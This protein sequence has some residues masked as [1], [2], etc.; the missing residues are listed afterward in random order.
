MCVRL[1]LKWQK[2]KYDRK[3]VYVSVYQKKRATNYHFHSKTQRQ[4]LFL[5]H[6]K[7]SCL[8]LLRIEI[9]KCTL[10]RARHLLRPIYISSLR[11]SPIVLS[12]MR[13]RSRIEQ[14]NLTKCT[15]IRGDRV[16]HCKQFVH[17]QNLNRHW[18]NRRSRF[19]KCTRL[20][21]SLSSRSTHI[22]RKRKVWFQEFSKPNFPSRS[23]HHLSIG[24]GIHWRHLHL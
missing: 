7:D 13:L 5:G 16:F 22:H 14:F 15:T 4:L 18:S 2:R 3:C 11:F 9:M 1:V 19:G 21:H 10:L 6:V 12:L 20:N 23:K 17:T 24:L 8:S